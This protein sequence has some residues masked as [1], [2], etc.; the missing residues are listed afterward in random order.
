M[1]SIDFLKRLESKEFFKEFKKDNPDAYLCAIFCILNKEETEGDK[2]NL[3]FFIPSKKKVA[4]SE[5]PFGEIFY[6]QEENKEY[7]ELKSLKDI[8]IDLED[9]WTEVEEIKK[10]KEIQHST[11]KIIGVLTEKEWNL[12]C[13]S[14]SMDLLKIKID[15]K[16]KEIIS[17][18]KESLS[19]MIKIQKK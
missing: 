15:S 4:Y 11:G 3:D 13:L 8:T 5:S 19:D 12:T 2:I 14:A 6:S 18:K 10:K 1:K 16:T 9:L 7:A 17:A